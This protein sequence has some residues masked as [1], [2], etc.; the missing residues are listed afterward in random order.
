VNTLSSLSVFPALSASGGFP[1]VF[2]RRGKGRGAGAL[3]VRQGRHDLEQ[4]VQPLQPAGQ[5]RG[6][7]IAAPPRL[8]GRARAEHLR[9]RRLQRPVLAPADQPG[10]GRNPS[11]AP[12]S[13]RS[14]P[15]KIRPQSPAGCRRTAERSA[16]PRGYWTSRP[17]LVSLQPSSPSMISPVTGSTV[18]ALV[19]RSRRP[20]GRSGR[21]G[22]GDGF[23]TTQSF[24]CH[25]FIHS[26]PQHR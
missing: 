15:F 14:P 8:R 3:A 5:H 26:A 19:Q 6:Q 12:R 24:R 22:T 20:H 2:D 10:P 7:L 16:A 23:R 13:F 21:L 4:D 25:E 1:P 17:P 9:H 11:R 18:Q